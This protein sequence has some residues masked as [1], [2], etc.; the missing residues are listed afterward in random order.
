MPLGAL[1]VVSRP[2]ALDT[3]LF[4]QVD[5]EPLWVPACSLF[6]NFGSPASQLGSEEGKEDMFYP[7][8]CLPGGPDPAELPYLSGTVLMK[9]GELVMRSGGARDL[10]A[11][12]SSHSVL[13]RGEVG[14]VRVWGL[15]ASLGARPSLDGYRNFIN[16]KWDL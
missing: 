5:D 13:C 15:S 9:T 14:P 16:I 8:I 7:E 12:G 10:Q 1:S 3:C 2:C 11:K 4:L 6:I